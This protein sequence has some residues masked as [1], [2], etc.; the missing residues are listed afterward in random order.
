MAERTRRGICRLEWQ[1]GYAVFSVSQS[2]LEQVKDYIARQEEHHQKMTLQDELRT[3]LR[4]HQ[5]EWNERY[6]WD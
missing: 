2:N 4:K 6:F 3:L 1:S 5:V